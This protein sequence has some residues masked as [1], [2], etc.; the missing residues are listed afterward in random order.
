MPLVPAVAG[1][2]PTDRQSVVVTADWE[3]RS[4]RVVQPRGCGGAREFLAAQEVAVY[5]RDSETSASQGVRSLN[6]Q[7][8][9]RLVP[10]LPRRNIARLNEDTAGA[11]SALSYRADGGHIAI[12]VPGRRRGADWPP[13]FPGLRSAVGVE[14]PMRHVVDE[15]S[16]AFTEGLPW[17]RRGPSNS[18][19]ARLAT[20]EPGAGRETGCRAASP[21]LVVLA[22]LR[23]AGVRDA[24]PQNWR[25]PSHPNWPSCVIGLPTR[26]PG[27]IDSCSGALAAGVARG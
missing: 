14:W 1:W 22:R 4:I 25:I 26:A 21:H 16:L 11:A 20:G 17:R 13:R 27:P 5:R 19:T 15:V 24:S 8:M 10:A 9:N 3:T 23:P 18:L 2:E 6:E 7:Q 12:A